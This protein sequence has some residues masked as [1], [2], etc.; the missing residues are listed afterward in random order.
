MK[1]YHKIGLTIASLIALVSLVLAVPAL[2]VES[3]E[4]V[5]VNSDQPFLNLSEDDDDAASIKFGQNLF[6]AGNNVVNS[7]RIY[8]QQAT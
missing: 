6:Y 2:A 3:R 1:R 4:G 7:A 5:P 8:S